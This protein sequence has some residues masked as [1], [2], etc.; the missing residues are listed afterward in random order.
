MDILTTLGYDPKHRII[1]AIIFALLFPKFP[2]RNF[3]GGSAGKESACNAGDLSSIPGWGRSPGEGNGNPLQYAC[4]ENPKDREP[5]GLP[6]TGS[7]RV[8]HN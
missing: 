5:D 8:G 6:S 7:H 4:L 2:L 3:P 1:K